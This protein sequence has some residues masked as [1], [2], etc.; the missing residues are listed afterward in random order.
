MKLKKPM[1]AYVQIK[2]DIVKRIRSHEW[3]IDEKLPSELQ[4]M[5]YYDVGRGTVRDAMKLVIEDGYA[6][7]K[8]GVGTFVAQHSVGISLEPFVSLTYFIQMRGLTITSKILETKTLEVGEELSKRTGLPVG[9]SCLFMKRL[10]ILEGDPFAV[11]EFYFTKE[12][13]EMFEGY[14]FT[15]PISNFM[16]EENDVSVSKMN[17]DFN[18]L[19]VEKELAEL[20]E[21]PMNQRMVLSS[22][23]VFV[24]PDNK[25]YYYLDFYAGAE[26]GLLG[27]N[28]FM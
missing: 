5:E 12:A 24:E 2:D 8:K 28:Q 1:P 27:K 17:M 4:L 14:D 21:I 13:Q 9:S 22:R 10:R 6:R 20:L 19:P 11:E 3:E 16:F 26:K 23:Q 25:I 18:I 7:I 15:K